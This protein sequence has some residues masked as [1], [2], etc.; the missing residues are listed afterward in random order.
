MPPDTRASESEPEGGLF[1][2]VRGLFR[3]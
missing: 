1:S 3:R 2:K